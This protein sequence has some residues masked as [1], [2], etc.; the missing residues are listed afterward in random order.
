MY[1]DDKK[2]GSVNREREHLLN[3]DF[4]Q[5]GRLDFAGDDD[6]KVAKKEANSENKPEGSST[7]HTSN[8]KEN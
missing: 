4:D 2:D 5:T 8:L 3:P 6:F 1:F 7:E